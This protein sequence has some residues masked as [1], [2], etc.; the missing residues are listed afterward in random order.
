LV[1]PEAFPSFSADILSV[2][3]DLSFGVNRDPD[4]NPNGAIR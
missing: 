4:V 1:Y 3:F 2:T